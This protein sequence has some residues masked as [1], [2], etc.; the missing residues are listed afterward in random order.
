VKAKV[1]FLL[2][3]LTVVVE[4]AEYFGEVDES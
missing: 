2:R 4:D 3:V 1:V